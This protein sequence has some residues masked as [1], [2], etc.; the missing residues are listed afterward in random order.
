[1]KKTN[2]KQIRKVLKA[3]TKPVTN[4]K[5]RNYRKIIT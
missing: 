2:K 3:N 1:M 5:Q 4:S